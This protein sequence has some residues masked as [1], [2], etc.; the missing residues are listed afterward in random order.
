MELEQQ[1]L[2]AMPT[3]WG[4]QIYPSETG[5]EWDVTYFDFERRR[6]VPIDSGS[7]V[8]FAATCSDVAM[9]VSYLA[10]DGF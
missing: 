6:W 5:Y 9:A 1:V 7:G 10:Q 2:F 8:T 3:R 4:V